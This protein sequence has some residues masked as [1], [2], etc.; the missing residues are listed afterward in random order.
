MAVIAL[1]GYFTL[2]YFFDKNQKRAGKKRDAEAS[3]FVP[4]LV[5]VI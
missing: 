3:Q 2:F 1:L 5:V 4:P